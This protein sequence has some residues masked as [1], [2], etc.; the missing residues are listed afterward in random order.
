MEAWR[1]SVPE[2]PLTS[3]AMLGASTSSG[4]LDPPYL[5]D[6]TRLTTSSAAGRGPQGRASLRLPHCTWLSTAGGE[7]DVGSASVLGVLRSR[8]S[9][10]S[11]RRT[12]TTSGRSV[13]LASQPARLFWP[14]VRQQRPDLSPPPGDG[15][16]NPRRPGEGG[17]ASAL[18][19]RLW[20]GP[21]P[22]RLHAGLPQRVDKGTLRVV[23]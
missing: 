9:L 4:S 15:R 17:V 19:L 14:R 22:G 8:P 13:C 7:P 23:L 10:A 3:E 1:T 11:G 5:E 21:P 6:K 20:A 16:T 12:L 2:V 18:Q